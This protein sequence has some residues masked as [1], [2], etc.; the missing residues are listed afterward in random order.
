MCFLKNNT[1][2]ILCKPHVASVCIPM[3]G[4]GP[5]DLANSVLLKFG[6]LYD[7]RTTPSCAPPGACLVSHSL[8]SSLWAPLSSL[9]WMSLFS[10]GRSKWKLVLPIE[11]HWKGSWRQVQ[12]IATWSSRDVGH[13]WVWYHTCGIL[14]WY[15]AF[16]KSDHEYHNEYH[17]ESY[18]HFH[19]FSPDLMTQDIK[20]LLLLFF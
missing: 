9:R 10:W 7:P 1:T 18:Y 17:P 5:W 15:L 16:A 6:I 4:G 20:K 11:L 2:Y 14:W 12:D 8:A 19:S 13:E 3:K